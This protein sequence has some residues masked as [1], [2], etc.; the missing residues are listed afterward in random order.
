MD[1]YEA[2]NLLLRCHYPLSQL[3][4]RFFKLVTTCFVSELV[5]TKWSLFE[6]IK[7]LFKHP[8]INFYQL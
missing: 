6:L 4:V 1:V 3:N 7:T 2:V 5:E 8:D